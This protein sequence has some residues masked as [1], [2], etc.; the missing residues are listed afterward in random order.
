M[1]INGLVYQVQFLQRCFPYHSL[2]RCIDIGTDHG[3][4]PQQLLSR[5]IV[6]HATVTDINQ[7]PLQ[8]AIGNFGASYHSQ[9]QFLI[10]DGFRNVSFDKPFDFAVIAG[11][12][13]ETIKQIMNHQYRNAIPFYILQ[14]MTA[15]DHLRQYLHS[16]GTILWNDVIQEGH[17]FY[18]VIVF[19]PT[20]SDLVEGKGEIQRI[21]GVPYVKEHASVLR[22]F[23]IKKAKTAEQIIESAKRSRHANSVICEQQK[24]YTFYCRMLEELSENR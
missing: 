4:L 19:S 6:N 11:M 7:G 1:R 22:S 12:G 18:E 2:H 17:K 13:G 5:K 21:S 20:I 24:K 15:Q 23:F 14:P 9:V 8:S 3:Y 16:I 10:S